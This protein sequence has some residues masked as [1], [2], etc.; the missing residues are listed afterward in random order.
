[1]KKTIVAAISIATLLVTMSVASAQICI[2]GIF[3]AAIHANMR[4]NRELTEKEALSCG[5]FYLSEPAKPKKEAARRPK[6]SDRK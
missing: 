5:L 4:D 6:H 1:M 2:V 3:A